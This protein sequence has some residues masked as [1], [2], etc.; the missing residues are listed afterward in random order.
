MLY[1]VSHFGN[2]F[3]SVNHCIFT[4]QTM[5]IPQAGAAVVQ[6]GVPCYTSSLRVAQTPVQVVKRSDTVSHFR[7]P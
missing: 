6:L 7:Q 2:L 5:Q 1:D 3:L 4:C